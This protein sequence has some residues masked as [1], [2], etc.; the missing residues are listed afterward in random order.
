MDNHFADMIQF[1]TMGTA[2]EGYSTQQKELV[3]HA[4]DFSV[5]AGDLYNMGMDEILRRYVPEFERS[6]ILVEAHGWVEGGY[7][8]GK[9]ATKNIFRIRLW[10]PT[11]HKDS[12]AYC[13]VCDAYQRTGKPS[14]RDELLLNP[15]ISLQV[16]DKWD[17]DFIG[18]IQP[19]GKKM[20]AQYIIT[21][22]EYLTR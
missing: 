9:V 2:L 22:T 3:V 21:A 6:S 20:G 13:K 1:L 8:V 19:S 4:A 7:Y 15:Q 5:I 16:F 10:W 18:P 17:I 14:W 11:L 12:K